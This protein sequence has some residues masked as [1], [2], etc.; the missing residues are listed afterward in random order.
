MGFTVMCSPVSQWYAAECSRVSVLEK[1]KRK[2]HG[3]GRRLSVSPAP[4]AFDPLRW[5]ALRGSHPRAFPPSISR[6]QPWILT[7]NPGP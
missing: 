2:E 5:E 1:G 6:S 7:C 4:I 3:R